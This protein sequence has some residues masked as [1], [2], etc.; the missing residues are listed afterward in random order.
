MDP[1]RRLSAP[2]PKLLAG[3]EMML[4][5]MFELGSDVDGAPEANSAQ[6]VLPISSNSQ[7]R[8]RGIARTIDLSGEC[9]NRQI[10]SKP[11]RF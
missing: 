6:Q 7:P 5:V 11:I 1:Y 10:G 4:G 8:S 2:V 9:A 3:N